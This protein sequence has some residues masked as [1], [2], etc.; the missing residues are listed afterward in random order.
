MNSS[1]NNLKD[2]S[3]KLAVNL[4][5]LRLMQMDRDYLRDFKDLKD[6]KAF[7]HQ[8]D[9]ERLIRSDGSLFLFNHSPTGSGKTIS[10]LKP[11]LDD[12]MR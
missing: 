3:E 4:D 5:G 10:W 8:I 7:E 6:F 11:V 1:E 12:R 9:S 2:N